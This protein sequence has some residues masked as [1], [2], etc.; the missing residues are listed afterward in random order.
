LEAEADGEVGM[1]FDL[2]RVGNT[3]FRRA[4]VIVAQSRS[5]IADPQEATIFRTQPAP[6]S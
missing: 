3:R 4:A 6:I 5:D 1:L 2:D